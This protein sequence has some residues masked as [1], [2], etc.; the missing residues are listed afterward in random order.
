MKRLALFCGLGLALLAWSCQ[1]EEKVADAVSLK[2][3]A[4]VFRTCGR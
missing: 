4:A 2:S 1:K 3:A